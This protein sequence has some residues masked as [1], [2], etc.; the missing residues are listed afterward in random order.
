M[1]KI[2]PSKVAVPG[3]I[4][5]MVSMG[6]W[7]PT[8]PSSLGIIQLSAFCQSARCKWHPLVLVGISLISR[9]IFDSLLGFFCKSLV[10]ILY[11]FLYKNFCL[12]LVD[13]HEFLV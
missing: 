5:P 4:P 6:L 13:W 9:H 7:I 1:G 10:R 8:A 11:S 2:L 12:I 3:Y